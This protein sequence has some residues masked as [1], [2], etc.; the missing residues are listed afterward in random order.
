M[1]YLEEPSSS[2]LFLPNRGMSHIVI[3]IQTNT[4]ETITAVLLADLNC[5]AFGGEP[6]PEAQPQNRE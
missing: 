2:L 6:A 5:T 1:L 3:V 4:R